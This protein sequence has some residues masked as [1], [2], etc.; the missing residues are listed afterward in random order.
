ML[1]T[2]A[3]WLNTDQ[4]TGSRD[5]SIKVIDNEQTC[6]KLKRMLEERGIKPREIQIQLRLD[7]IQAVYKWLNPKYKTM[8]SL[9]NLIL[10]AQYMDCRLEDILVLNEIIE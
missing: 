10:L 6:I 5:L 3:K 7:S 4:I 2:T 9:D 1:S 8:P